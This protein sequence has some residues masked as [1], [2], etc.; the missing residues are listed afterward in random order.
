MDIALDSVKRENLSNSVTPLGVKG[1][2]GARAKVF[3]S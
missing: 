3:V 1:L 2:R